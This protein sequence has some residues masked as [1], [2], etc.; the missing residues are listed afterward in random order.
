MREQI[1]TVMAPLLMRYGEMEVVVGVLEGGQRVVVGLGKSSIKGP[2]TPDGKNMYEIGS[3]T[4]VFTTTLLAL[5]VRDGLVELEMPV[6]ELLPE[7]SNLPDEMTLLRLATH[8]SGLPRLPGN[9]LWSVVRSPRNPYKHYGERQ[10][11]AFLKGYRPHGERR[12]IYPYAYSN[13]GVGLLAYALARKLGVSYEVAIREWVCGRLGMDDTG[14]TLTEEQQGRL[15]APHNE[16][17]K[18]MPLWDMNAL[19]G[20]GALRSDIDDLLTFVSMHLDQPPGALHEIVPLC[21]RIYV[22]NPNTTIMGIALG[23]H[24]SA[25]QDSRLRAYWHNGAT[26]GCM[27]FVGFV[28]ERNVG[29]AMVSNY[30]VG[31]SG[32][33]DITEYGL[34]I[35]EMVAKLGDAAL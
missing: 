28:K 9:I 1:E 15:I 18:V 23:W 26:Y 32:G 34:R 4:K 31:R 8:T 29:V 35:L 11:H 14:I 30:G 6:R 17:G 13:L 3:V 33:T 12:A 2:G 21:H 10:L 20:A 22:E 24:V 25:L 7:F 16:R 27:G 5:M 19:A